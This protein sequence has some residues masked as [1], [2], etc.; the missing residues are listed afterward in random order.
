MDTTERR[1]W[2]E[3]E[4]NEGK[5]GDKNGSEKRRSETFAKLKVVI[6]EVVMK[7]LE[8]WIINGWK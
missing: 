4:G 1:G 8:E 6:K 2:E 7:K 3:K 5:R